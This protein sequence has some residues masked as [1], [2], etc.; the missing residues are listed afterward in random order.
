MAKI[1]KTASGK[2]SCRLYLGMDSSKHKKYKMFTHSDKRILKSIVAEFESTNRTMASLD[3]FSACLERYIND[4]DGI[5]SPSTIRG[6]KS[7][8]EVLKKDFADFCALSLASISRQDI[9]KVITDLQSKD[10]SGKYIKN[11]HGLISGVL[12]ANDYPSP[13][14]SLP[15]SKAKHVYEPSKDDIHRT[16]M[17]AHGTDMEIPILLGIHGLRRSEICALRYPEDFEG[18]VIHVRHAIVY[19]EKNVVSEKATKTDGSDR[20]VPLS[21]DCYQKIVKQG[22]VTHKTLAAITQ[23][24]TRLLARNGIP[25]Y[26]FHD[27]RHFFASYMHENGFSDAQIMKMGGWKTDA[28]MKNI[29]RYALPDEKL[30]DKINSVFSNL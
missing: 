22:Y 29:Y 17:A 4:R 6:Y 25:K 12:I 3:T 14:V 16:L 27:L 9:Q 30:S 20:L 19:G 18:K 1:V 10:K 21:D 5:V 2:F 26:R 23:A 11:I 15:S 24:F 13:K 28:V 8:Q 7:I